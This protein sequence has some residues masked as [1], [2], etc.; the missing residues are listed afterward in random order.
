MFSS[1]K[2]KQGLQ[3]PCLGRASRSS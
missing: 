2:T 3:K 1:Y